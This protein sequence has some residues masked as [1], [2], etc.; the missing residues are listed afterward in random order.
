M[1]ME[2]Q[3]ILGG[4]LNLNNVLENKL[5]VPLT[6]SKSN[7]TTEQSIR[8]YKPQGHAFQKAYGGMFIYNF[9]L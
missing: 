1:E 5:A 2:A 6:S 7:F 4:S 3:V 8:G 9:L